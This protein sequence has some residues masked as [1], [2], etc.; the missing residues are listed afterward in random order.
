[1]NRNKSKH[2][3]LTLGEKGK[4]YLAL[5]QTD[6][7]T[8]A[9]IYALLLKQNKA[10]QIIG[11]PKCEVMTFDNQDSATLYFGTLEKLMLYQHNRFP[12]IV[13]HFNDTIEKFYEH[14]K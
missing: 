6:D 14:T 7:G 2:P 8:F 11:N 9:Y 3:L 1:M 5:S 4:F 13:S 12:N 10:G